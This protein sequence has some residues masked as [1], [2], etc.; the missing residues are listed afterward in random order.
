MV[1][2]DFIFDFIDVVSNTTPMI[3]H[4]I[5]CHC[6]HHHT[7]IGSKGSSKSTNASASSI[8]TEETD[9]DGDDLITLLPLIQ[10]CLASPMGSSS[11]DG[12]NNDNNDTAVAAVKRCRDTNTPFGKLLGQ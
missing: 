5:I 10:Q 2:I 9:G 11:S 7:T 1:S 12:N 6:H 8:S 3:K 4:D